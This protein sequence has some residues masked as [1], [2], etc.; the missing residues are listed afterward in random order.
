MKKIYLASGSPRRKELL[1]SINLDFEII[2]N[3]F[4][5][6]FNAEDSPV[7][8][9]K[10]LSLGKAENAANKLEEGIVIGA[11]TLVFFNGKILGKPKDKKEA[12]N[13]LKTLSGQELEVYTGVALVDLESNNFL[14][15]Y[16]VSKLKIKDL[17]ENEILNYVAT[18]EPLDK[19][20]S[21]GPQNK[22][23]LIIEK[24]EGDYSNILGLPLLKL[25]EMLKKFGVNCL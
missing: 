19:A 25:S 17:T 15:D 22:G 3:D 20:G 21:F 16:G 5:E 1:E 2:S 10:N 6:I 18:E 7:D 24:I 11:D 9:V 8:T 23:A 4:E 13:T 14:V 12:I